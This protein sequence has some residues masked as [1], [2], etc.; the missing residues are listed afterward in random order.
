MTLD[1][2]LKENKD[3]KQILKIDEDASEIFDMALKLEG[4]TRSVGKHAA[5][6]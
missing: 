5:G 1:R 4:T 6:V 3:L 2:A